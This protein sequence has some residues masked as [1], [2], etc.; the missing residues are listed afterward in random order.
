MQSPW[1]IH[2]G[3]RVFYPDWHSSAMSHALQFAA[4]TSTLPIFK[5]LAATQSGSQAVCRV[6]REPVNPFLSLGGMP[7]F[8]RRDSQLLP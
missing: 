5:K 4:K 3:R 7:F 6:L 8:D 1:L 2:T